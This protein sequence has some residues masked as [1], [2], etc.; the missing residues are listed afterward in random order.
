M[1]IHWLLLLAPGLF[2]A[3]AGLSGPIAGYLADPT[4]PILRA[5]SGVPG[6]YLLGDPIA[7]PAGL[8][9]LHLAPGKDFALAE[10][11]D[12]PPA[13]LFLA[14][15]AVD[16]LIPLSGVMPSAEW[17]AFSTGAASAV[18][19]SSA[20]GRLQVVT[21]L[22]DS[23]QV[24]FDLDASTLPEQPLSAAVSDDAKLVVMSSANSVYRLSAGGAP[25]LLL[26]AGRI[27]SVAVLPNGEVAVSET[28]T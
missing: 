17:V 25:Q 13:V 4:R 3:D 26:S 8:T 2:A 10:S 1:R 18:L 27:A 21:G 9:R 16:R 12:A 19:F 5:I 22:P 15:G 14:A 24:A 28:S 11:G 20:A 7:L 23:P 6:A